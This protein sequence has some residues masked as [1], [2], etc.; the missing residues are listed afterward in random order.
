MILVDKRLEELERA[1]T[2]VRIAMI[3]AGFMARG[4]ALQ[5]ATAVRGMRLSCIVCRTLEKGLAALEAAGFRG[6]R[7]VRSAQELEQAIAD[8]VPAVTQD[9]RIAV[10]CPQIHAVLEVTGSVDYGAQVI[11]RTIEQR[12]HAVLMNPELDGVVGPLLFE[13]ATRAGV[14]YTNVEGDQPGV[15]LNLYRFVKGIGATPVLCGNIKGLHDPYR[16]PTTQAGFAARWGQNVRMVTSFADGTKISFEQAIVANATGF[17]VARRGMLGPTVEPGT[18]VSQA[19]QWYPQEVLNTAP[20]FVDYVVGAEPSPG[21]FVI[22]RQEHPVQRHYLK[23]Y[24]LG[25]GPFYTFYTPYH[26]C[27]MEVPTTIARAALFHDAAIAPL[28]GPCVDVVA[29]AKTDLPAGTFL[30]GLGGYTFYG[31]AENYAAARRENLLPAGLG[32]GCRLKRDVARDELLRYEDVELPGDSFA[33]RLR[34]QMEAAFREAPR[35]AES[36]GPR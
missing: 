8:E 31:L 34:F 7:A 18:H 1:G 28:Y 6:S 24:K 13:A 22:A 9:Y 33:V 26:L 30:D 35:K 25:D 27:H 11:W 19:P 16:N 20:G 17:Q 14:V 4:I 21:V 29:A 3:G 12:K 15:I 10:D 2:P 5:F 32:E 36:A 23:L